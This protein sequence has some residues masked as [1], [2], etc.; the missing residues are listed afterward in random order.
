MYGFNVQKE[1]LFI[2]NIYNKVEI[3]TIESLSILK[4]YYKKFNRF[5]E[6]VILFKICCNKLTLL[7]NDDDQQILK[8]F[9]TFDLDNEGD[10]CEL[11]DSID[12]FKIIKKFGKYDYLDKIIGFAYSNIIKFKKTENIKGKY[13]LLLL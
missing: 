4:N 10:I 3:S 8:E 1:H 5:L 11:R 12:N 7:K 2:R 6:T 13:F 9:F